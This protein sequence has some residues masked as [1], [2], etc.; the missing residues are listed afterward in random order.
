MLK[1]RSYARKNLGYLYAI[2][3]GAK[4]IYETDDD[5]S[6]TTGNIGFDPDSKASY[7]VYDTNNRY[8]VNPYAH[9]GQSSIWPRGYP[10]DRISDG[11]IST[12]RECKN[13]R[14]LIQQG[15]V[16][17]DPDVDAIFRLTR[18][19]AN[20]S[21]KVEFDGDSKPIMLPKGIMS[22]YNS[23]NTLH[24]YDSF[25]GL[26]LPQTVSFR[27]CDIWR[28]YWAQRLLWEL[29]GYLTFFPPNAVTVRNSHDYLLDFID[30][31]DLYHKSSRLVKF[32]TKWRSSKPKFFDRVMDLSIEM[33]REGFWGNDDVVLVKLWLKDLISIG[34][35]PPELRE[36][37]P[38]CDAKVQTVTPK[39]KPSSYL[40]ANELQ[41]LF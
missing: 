19:D 39:E 7:L 16:N 31:K 8:V 33:A 37:L 22:P 41:L 24:L 9:F 10:L 34:Y 35:V 27:V 13:K 1:Y 28:G 4:I 36:S 32:L 3:H 18:K 25:F 23:Q 2:Q 21:L 26:M 12:F 11:P 5:N 20:V 17:G 14:A 40:R 15:V 30:E 29:D 6:P 38:S